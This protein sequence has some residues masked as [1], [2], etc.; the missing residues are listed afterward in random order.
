MSNITSVKTTVFVT[1][2]IAPVPAALKQSLYE[3]LFDT[4]WRDRREA[5]EDLRVLTDSVDFDNCVTAIRYQ[6]GSDFDSSMAEE[7]GALI[8]KEISVWAAKTSIYDAVAD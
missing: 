2:A 1:Y 7:V 8:E 3:H 5:E 6:F 4:V